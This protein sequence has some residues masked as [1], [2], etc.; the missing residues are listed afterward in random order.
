M[1]AILCLLVFLQEGGVRTPDQDPHK[2]AQIDPAKEFPLINQQAD[3]V[4]KEMKSMTAKVKFHEIDMSAGRDEAREGTLKVKRYKNE[5]WGLVVCATNDPPL[6]NIMNKKLTELW[7]DSKEY[8]RTEHKKESFPVEAFLA[9]QYQPSK[10]KEDF[11]LKLVRI[12]LKYKKGDAKGDK[13]PT[14]DPFAKQAGE[15]EKENPSESVGEGPDPNVHHV[16]ELVPKEKKLKASISSITLH[17]HFRTYL[18]AEIAVKRSEDGSRS[19]AI[20]LS[21][22]KTDVELA[23]KDVVIETTEWKAKK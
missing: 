20:T 7:P 17:V 5:L 3:A 16:V 11:E 21:D 6:R 4:L 9:W 13:P 18:F 2:K 14:D 12:A 10:L 15:F 22:S 1:D 8:R 19:L 23:D